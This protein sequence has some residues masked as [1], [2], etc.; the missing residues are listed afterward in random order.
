M[1]IS[2][3]ASQELSDQMET[4]RERADVL[5][6][7]CGK[8][9]DNLDTLVQDASPTLVLPAEYDRRTL[10]LLLELVDDV[11]D[12]RLC[13]HHPHYV[14]ELRRLILWLADNA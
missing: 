6:D 11:R 4:L 14:D 12:R 1:S 8:V 13:R 5:A 2:R 10:L 9:A 7:M 3:E